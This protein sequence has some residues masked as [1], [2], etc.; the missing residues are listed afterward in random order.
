MDSDTQALQ[1]AFNVLE[2]IEARGFAAFIA[3]GAVR[4]YLLKKQIHDIDIATSMPLTDLAQIYPSKNMGSSRDFG[5]L[6]I[7]NQ[8][9]YFEVTELRG[10]KQDHSS[11]KVCLSQKE[12]LFHQ[13]A[14]L[15]DFTVNAMALDSSERI[16]DPC[17]G[18]E[19]LRNRVI[20]TPSQP[21]LILI[22]DPLRM[23]RAVRF[24]CELGFSI[25]GSTMACIRD[26]AHLISKPA[27]ERISS[28]FF[29]MCR[30]P[31]K[32]FAQSIMLMDQSGLL[33][34]ILPE[35]SRLKTFTHNFKHHPEGGV[36]EHTMAALK[37]NDT[38]DPVINLSILFHDSGK[39]A[40]F[41]I[42]DGQPTYYRH[43]KASI[44]IIRSVA[45][46]LKIPGRI[47]G[48][49]AFA[50]ENHM[51]ALKIHEM[52][53]SKI[54]RL[55]SEPGWPVLKKTVEC[56]IQARGQSAVEFKRSVECLQEK[57]MASTR[58]NKSD[59]RFVLTGKQVMQ[60]TG[61][62]QGPEIGRILKLTTDWALDNHIKDEKKIR[63]YVLMLTKKQ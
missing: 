28:E 52:K 18:I 42:R 26:N 31:G 27:S 17:N 34:I 53:P 22:S 40:T 24:A 51:K 25:E 63:D 20:K 8:G 60:Y 3:G 45:R 36:F 41:A 49:V 29:K 7:Q 62:P 47:L 55:M 32:V 12:H 5:T 37:A 21:D 44:D 2:N 38:A 50:A 16:L 33:E 57:I 10:G 13:D 23:L 15:R 6:L 56:D 58:Q 30:L 19:D 9:R 14:L 46:R 54:Y 35:I 39:A 59:S 11:C 61:L 4:D 48:Q 43:E 1:S